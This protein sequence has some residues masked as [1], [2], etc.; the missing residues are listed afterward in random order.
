[1]KKGISQEALAHECGVHRTFMGTVER[2]ESNLSFQNLSRIAAAL[3]VTMSEL[4]AAT[5]TKAGELEKTPKAGRQ[6][7][8]RLAQLEKQR[9]AT[10]KRLA[11]LVAAQEQ[12]QQR[13]SQL[14]QDIRRSSNDVERVTRQ[15]E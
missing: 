2:G 13:L 9:Q 6:A 1:M 12:E 14:E 11:D 4:L 8:R 15:K 5:E 3:G 10:E 7:L